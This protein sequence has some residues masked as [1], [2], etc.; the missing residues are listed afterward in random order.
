[1]NRLLLVLIAMLLPGCALLLNDVNSLS[2]VES[3]R[4]YRSVVIYGIE[5]RS[6]V[7]RFGVSF[8]EYDIERQ[9]IT[10]NCFRYNRMQARTPVRVG[11]MNYFVFDVAPGHYVYSAGSNLEELFTPDVEKSKAFLIPAGKTVYLGD[12]IWVKGQG[13]TGLEVRG[14]KIVRVWEGNRIERRNSLEAMKK[15]LH[16]SGEVVD[17]ETVAVRSPGGV[18][19]GV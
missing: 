18:L 11:T 4:S 19:C 3:P 10:G 13:R 14:D 8:D 1:M 17:A 16:V 9:R 7:P 6:G 12:F 2:H 15:A 5:T